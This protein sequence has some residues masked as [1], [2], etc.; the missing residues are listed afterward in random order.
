MVS[1][2]NIS[3]NVFKKINETFS[4]PGI[5]QFEEGRDNVISKIL[6]EIEND[7]R[8]PE[9]L[10]DLIQYNVGI[11]LL[12]KKYEK[13]SLH[14]IGILEKLERKIEF[15]EATLEQE[16]KRNPDVYNGIRLEKREIDNLILINENHV[17]LVEKKENIKLICQLYAD[18]K[19]RILKS[20]FS[21]K[22][23]IDAIKI[24]LQ[25]Y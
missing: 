19:D 17:K 25:A 7:L 8:I 5:K 20:A 15:M 10:E 23:Q 6:D 1:V 22:N 12:L 24:S 2:N 4:S 3:D 18:A 9:K 14:Y 21:I 11:G 13:E 16:Y